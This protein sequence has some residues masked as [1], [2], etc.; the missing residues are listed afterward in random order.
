MRGQRVQGHRLRQ[1]TGPAQL[2]IAETAVRHEAK[3][4]AELRVISQFGMVIQRQVESHQVDVGAKQPFQARMFLADDPGVLVF[5]EIAVMDQDGIGAGLD[6]RVDEGQAGRHAGHHVGD[7][8]STLHLEA[9][10]AIV[11]ET[12]NFQ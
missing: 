6:R 12:R 7:L 11:L 3:L 2:I 9:V 8:R 10:R 1:R 5:P 4:Q